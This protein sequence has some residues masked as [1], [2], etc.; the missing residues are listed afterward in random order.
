MSFEQIIQ[1]HCARSV[2]IIVVENAIDQLATVSQVT[3]AIAASDTGGHECIYHWSS[4]SGLQ[5]VS[6]DDGTFKFS[7]NYLSN[8]VAKGANGGFTNNPVTA[9]TVVRE[10]INETK[11]SSR[12]DRAGFVFYMGDRVLSEDNPQLTQ[13]IQLLLELRDYLKANSSCVYLVGTNFSIPKELKEHVAVLEAPLPDEPAYIKIIESCH[14]KLVEAQKTAEVESEFVLDDLTKQRF[15]DSLKGMSLFAAEQIVY[16]S[17]DLNGMHVDD[18]RQRSI[19]QINSTKGLTVYNGDGRGFA[20]LGGLNEIKEYSR[21]LLTG[22]LNTKLVVYL[23]EVEKAIAGSQSNGDTTGI[24]Q[25]FLG[26]LL[27]EMQDTNSLGMILSGVYGAGKSEF[28]KRFGEE[29]GT[30]CIHMDISGMK[31]SLVGNSEANLRRAM[32]TIKSIGGTDGGILYMATCNRPSLLPP[33]FKRRFNL[34][35]FFFYF[36]DADEKKVIWDIYLKMY[37]LEDDKTRELVRDDKWTGAEIESC[38]RL[39]HL[40]KSDLVTASSRIVPVA[41]MSKED[42]DRITDEASGKFLSVSQPGVFQRPSS[43]KKTGSA[44]VR[45]TSFN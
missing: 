26:T 12:K 14:E 17:T 6:G 3:K 1:R 15:S 29:A 39:A 27:S 8:A 11:S 35:T 30:L 43:N 34:G 20:A 7:E 33:E 25:N 5:T 40:M 13:C 21:S 41:T 36:P 42:I 4:V 18:M 37:G 44:T 10:V 31:D 32:H 22:R 23:D 16:L 19:Q 24:S 9:L 45:P 2:P 28:A 38:C